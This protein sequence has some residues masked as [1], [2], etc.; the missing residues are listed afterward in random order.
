MDRLVWIGAVLTVAGV[1][2]LLACVWKVT[3]AR[4]SG[5]DDD[6]MRGVLQQVVTLNLAALGVSALGL[7][8][9]VAGLVL[10]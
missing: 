6:G 9:V 2:G 5:L 7:G 1:L 10:R 3:R 4:R 8:C